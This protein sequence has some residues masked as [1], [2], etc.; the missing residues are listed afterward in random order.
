MPA[1]SP[2]QPPPASRVTQTIPPPPGLTPDP[3]PNPTL[4]TGYDVTTATDKRRRDW[5]CTTRKRM[6]P[7]FGTMTE[8]FE[9]VGRCGVVCTGCGFVHVDGE[10]EHW[11]A[12]DQG[13]GFDFGLVIGDDKAIGYVQH[14]VES[15]YRFFD[16]RTHGKCPRTNCFHHS[17][18]SPSI[19]EYKL[20]RF[21]RPDHW[22]LRCLPCAS[23]TI[24]GANDEFFTGRQIYDANGRGSPEKRKLENLQES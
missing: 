14:C 5:N 1:P 11:T 17:V 13:G 23:E 3:T 8:R 10:N 6:S 9:M 16:Y 18:W 12:E 15:M 20:C 21:H 4:V 7:V 24:N 19:G 2:A 22:D